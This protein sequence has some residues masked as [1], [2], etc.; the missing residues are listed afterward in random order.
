MVAGCTVRDLALDIVSATDLSLLPQTT[1]HVQTPSPEYESELE[2]TS[3][4]S[5]SLP[6]ATAGATTRGRK[7]CRLDTDMRNFAGDAGRG[8]L[9][10]DQD[11]GESCKGARL[12]PNA[13][14]TAKRL[15]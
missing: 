6:S 2:T 4:P 10:S 15:R 11:S 1:C 5:D 9:L 3:S 7:N 13:C 8:L 12:S 14:S